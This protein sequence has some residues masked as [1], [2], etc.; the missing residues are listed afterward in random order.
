M[1][2]SVE[3]HSSTIPASKVINDSDSPL[4]LLGVPGRLTHRTVKIGT[5]AAVWKHQV[6]KSFSR[7][8]KGYGSGG[9]MQVEIRF[10]DE[11]GNGHNSFAI[12]ASIWTTASRRQNDIQAGGCLHEEIEEVFPELAPLIKWHLVSTDSPMHYVANAVYHASDCKNGRKKGEPSAWKN[13]FKFGDFPI[14]HDIKSK[15][16]S[17]W[18]IPAL[19][20]NETTPAS[21]QNRPSFK[22]VEVPHVDSSPGSYKFSPKVTFEGFPCKWHES[23]FDSVREAEEFLAAIA[24]KGIEVVRVVTEYSEGKERDFAAAR[25]AACWPEATDEQL[26]VSKEELTAALASRLPAMIAEFRTAMES[27]G[28]YWSPADYWAGQTSL[29]EEDKRCARLINQNAPLC[30][31]EASDHD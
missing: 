17:E 27:I 10:D 15:A 23:P 12:T 8:V 7:P 5:P 18:L 26:S 22:I 3:K 6:W 4:A 28:F 14:L 9:E 16:F 11:C 24:Q 1:E 31:N 13:F 30:T 20:F 2:K 25:E 19:I 21:N 29:T